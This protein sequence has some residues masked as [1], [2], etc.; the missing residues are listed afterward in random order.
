MP[1]P[2]IT[3]PTLVL[4]KGGFVVFI[5]ALPLILLYAKRKEWRKCCRYLIM[6]LIGLFISYLWYR[7][8]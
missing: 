7:T 1:S 5:L 4:W 3:V 6:G 8:N 2:I